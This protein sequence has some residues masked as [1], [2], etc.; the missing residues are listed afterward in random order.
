MG[1]KTQLISAKIAAKAEDL[2]LV[3]AM[4]GIANGGG[5]FSLQA[6]LSGSM[7]KPVFNL[8]LS[9]KG[10]TAEKISL[11]NLDLAI[12]S[13]PGALKNGPDMDV[14]LSGKGIAISG[15]RR[16]DGIETRGSLSKGMLHIQQADFIRGRSLVKITGAVRLLEPDSL[17]RV[18]RPSGRLELSSKDFHLED[19]VENT[20]GS[21]TIQSVVEGHPKDFKGFVQVQGEKILIRNQSI[22]SISLNGELVKDRLV[23]APLLLVARN[24]KLRVE[25]WV[26]T[27]KTFQ[28][29]T[30]V[31]Q[32]SLEPWFAG[33]NHPEFSGNV[34]GSLEI[35]GTAGN[36]VSYGGRLALSRLSV[37]YHRQPLVNAR[38]VLVLLENRR[39]ELKNLQLLFEGDRELKVTGGISLEGESDVRVSGRFPLSI[40]R[41]FNENFHD[42]SGEM[43]LDGS[44]AGPLSEP[45]IHGDIQVMDL[46]TMVPGITQ[47]VHNTR[48]RVIVSPEAVNFESITGQLDSGTFEF[49]GQIDLDHF[50]PVGISGALKSYR[51]PVSIPD[52]LDMTLNTDLKIRGDFENSTIEG[53]LVL[54]EGLY[55]KDVNLNP[56]IAMSGAKPRSGRRAESPKPTLAD[57]MALNIFVRNRSPLV[58]SNNVSEMEIV[59]DLKIKGTLSRP[60]VLGRAHVESGQLMYRKRTFEIKKGIIDFLNPYKTEPSLDIQGESRIRD[61]LVTLNLS[62]TPDELLFS[63]SSDPPLDEGDIFSLVVLGKTSGEMTGGDS[64]SN[65]SAAQML[66]RIM[67]SSLNEDLQKAMGLDI[68]ETEVLEEQDG[69]GANEM[70]VTVGKEINRRLTMKYSARTEDGQI[71]QRTIAEY[72][73]IENI[74]VNVFQGTRGVLGGSIKY[75]LE[76]R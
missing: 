75:R 29:K 5:N 59:P 38:Q 63:F 76:W 3:A 73:F 60:I 26:A 68:L 58:V 37:F 44:M 23:L 12:R 71:V 46:Q 40:L 67:A 49:T 52:T 15:V 45:A 35:S 62:G 42:I 2:G 4:A 27:D 48:G 53:A 30:N 69:N 70:K 54:L 22:E 57:G 36:A 47:K 17:Q 56:I 61:W 51:L 43:R 72:K 66:S 28:L 10:L 39:V 20:R 9:A 24:Q 13:R 25:G 1:I 19:F 18:K 55:Y 34:T 74:L 6:D 41:I 50:K 7:K 8:S 14:S 33:L 16:L 64:L 32:S 31:D 21:F 11:D 65:Q